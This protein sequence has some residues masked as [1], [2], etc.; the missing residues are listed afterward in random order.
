M[1]CTV[2]FI[3]ASISYIRAQR[4]IHG[5]VYAGQNSGSPADSVK[6]LTASGDT[7]FTNTSGCY[8]IKTNEQKD[9]LYISYKGKEFYHFIVTNATP[10]KFDVYLNN[11]S[12]FNDE[13]AHELKQ[14]EVHTRNYHEDSLL[15]RQKYNGIFTYERPKFRYGKE[16]ILTPLG[17]GMDIDA[18]IRVL[19]FQEK[20]K[21]SRYKRFALQSEDQLYIDS[22]FTRSLAGRITHLDDDNELFAFMEWCRP[23]APQLRMMNDLELSQYVS[24][25][26]KD[27]QHCKIEKK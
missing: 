11:P 9:T 13:N 4:T 18:L 10:D 12:Y 25:E 8:T 1:L 16:W 19:Q 15:T 17:G 24:D 21:Q 5:H 3:G 20:H 14:V 7:A 6:L 27:Y 23:T 26:F 22:R 2:A